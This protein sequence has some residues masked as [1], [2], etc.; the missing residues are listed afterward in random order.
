MSTLFDQRDRHVFVAGGTSGINLAIAAAFGRAGAKL[1]LLG[2]NADR[3]QSA[4]ATVEAGGAQARF[5]SADV[6]QSEAVSAAFAQAQA[7][8]GPID[9]LISGA[10]GNFPAPVLGM[11]ER[12]FRSVIDIDLIGSFNVARFGHAHLRA[13]GAVVLMISAPQ[14]LLPSMLQAHVAAAKA[15]VDM[16]MRSLCLEWGP[17]GIR[18]NSIIPGP[19]ADTEGF[20]R[21]APTAQT[22]EAVERSVPLR[23]VGTGEDVANL[24]LFLASPYA[25]YIH[26]AVIPVDGGWLNGGYSVAAEAI[27]T[28]FMGK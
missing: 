10:A 11:S 3:G 12:A 26:G 18:L 4:V 8:H 20:R 17:Q 2:R 16:L 19:I 7:A 25:S 9:V 13:P 27:L 21:L 1:S 14:A 28:A 24:A 23:R 15:G 6:R 22:A 5:F